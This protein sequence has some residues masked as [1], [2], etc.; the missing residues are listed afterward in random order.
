MLIKGIARSGKRTKELV[1]KL[2]AHEIAIIDH[3]DIDELAAQS[4]VKAKVKAVINASPSITGK[5]PHRGPSV[6][7]ESGIPVLEQV[8]ADVFAKINDGMEIQ[9]K[10]QEIFSDHQLLGQGKVLNM[11]IIAEKVRQ[12][13]KNY[14]IQLGKFINNTLEYAAKEIKLVDQKLDIPDLGLDFHGR[15]TL[16]VVRGK[17][18][19]DDLNVIRPYINEIKPIL[20]GVDGGA[21]ALRSFGYCPHLIIGDMDS[22]SDRTLKCGAKLIV[23]AYPNGRAPGMERISSLGLDASLLPAP[24][25]SEDAAM[26]LSYQLGTELIVAVGTHSNVIDFLEKGRQGMASTFLVRLK[27]GSILVDAKGVSKLYRQKLKFRYIAQLVM[28][29]LIPFIIVG[30]VSPSAS[31]FLRLLYLK[32]RI[33]L[34]I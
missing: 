13:E 2:Q 11:K 3:E 31:Q 18:Y 33:F 24:G 22:I 26:L 29:A 9:I 15:H 4:L 25:T 32:V 1:K 34:R 21:D 16:I 19:L 20:I 30:L 6:L 28:A 14:H 27:I 5:Y 7:I 23:H 12:A 17:D 10:G 8:G